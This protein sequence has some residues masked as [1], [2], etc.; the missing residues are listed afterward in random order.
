MIYNIFLENKTNELVLSIK[1][2]LL[3]GKPWLPERT[4]IRCRI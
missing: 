1:I 4:R 3:N 2:K